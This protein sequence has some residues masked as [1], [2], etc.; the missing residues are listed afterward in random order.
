MEIARRCGLEVEKVP[1]APLGSF[2]TGPALRFARQGQFHPLRYLSGLAAAIGRHQGTVYTGVH[3]EKIE[4]GSPA[5]VTT[6]TGR[7]V[8]ADAVIVATNVPVNDRL[9]IHTKQAPYRTYVVGLRL[10]AGTLSPALFWDTGDPYHY[11]RLQGDAGGEVLIVG[12]EDH[13]TGQADDTEERFTRLERW[14]RERV[15]AAQDVLYHWSG[16]VLEPADS[17]AFI[18][19]NPGDEHVYVATGDSGQGMTHG[20]I[21]GILL[22]DLVMG[23]KNAWATLYDPGRKSLRAAKDYLKEMAESNIPYK[24]WVTRGE[25]AST[26][27]VARGEGALMRKGLTKVAVYRDSA[28]NVTEVSAV[29]RHLG[30]LVHWN[31]SEKSWDCPCHGS[32]YAPDG[33]VVN[34]PAATGLPLVKRD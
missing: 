30:C 23:R 27:D 24:D 4:D 10:P 20:T 19:R 14:T 5:R 6:A 7:T 12:G 31:S 11:V 34:G 26:E 2:D 17:L 22:T 15:P 25:V 8:T 16:Q 9:V 3:V 13:R 28:G 21:A 18:G 1:R 29:C 32:R 33:H